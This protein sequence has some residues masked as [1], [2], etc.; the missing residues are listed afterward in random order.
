MHA[1]HSLCLQWVWLHEC[2]FDFYI[3][4][5]LKWALLDISLRTGTMCLSQ[6]HKTDSWTRLWLLTSTIWLQYF[7][8]ERDSWL[9]A[10]STWWIASQWLTAPNIINVFI[11][12]GGCISPRLKF[13]SQWLWNATQRHL[14]PCLVSAE[15]QR[16]CEK[17][18]L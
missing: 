16:H 12:I 3:T 9:G 2:F 18:L 5:L 13:Y 14:Q 11:S 8:T 10:V 6:M 7:S 15:L 1:C 17:I 4:H